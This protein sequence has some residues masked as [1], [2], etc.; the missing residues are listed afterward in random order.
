MFQDQFHKSNLA[1]YFIDE[2]RR[3]SRFQSRVR[4]VRIKTYNSDLL[5]YRYKATALYSYLQKGQ[6]ILKGFIIFLNS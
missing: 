6:F 4:L 3:I 5:T 2:D 1:M